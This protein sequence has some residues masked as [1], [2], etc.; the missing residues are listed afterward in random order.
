MLHTL[1]RNKKMHIHMQMDIHMYRV[2]VYR[3][4]VNIH[5]RGVGL[6]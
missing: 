1:I 4:Y 2:H 3:V 6:E 5:V